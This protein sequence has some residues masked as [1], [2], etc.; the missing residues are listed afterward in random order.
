M[1]FILF[2]VFSMNDMQLDYLLVCIQIESIETCNI[3]IHSNWLLELYMFLS[4]LISILQHSN[5]FTKYNQALMRLTFSIK[6]CTHYISKSNNILIT[7]YKI[8]NR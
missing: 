5:I 3:W 2:R 8:T 4:L 1:E 6:N 7:I